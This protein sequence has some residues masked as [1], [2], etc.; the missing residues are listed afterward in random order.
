M[1]G[2]IQNGSIVSGYLK[3]FKVF[4]EALESYEGCE[5]FA[6]KVSRWDMNKLL[7]SWSTAAEP[8]KNGFKVLNHGEEN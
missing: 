3:L 7:A 2:I 5:E 8:M 1:K 4:V 6:E